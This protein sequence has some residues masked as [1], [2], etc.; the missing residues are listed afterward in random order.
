MDGMEILLSLVFVA[1]AVVWF[2]LYVRGKTEKQGVFSKH[3]LRESEEWPEPAVAAAEAVRPDASRYRVMVPLANPEHESSLITLAGSIAKQHENG[4]VVVVHIVEVPYQVPLEAGARRVDELD[5]ESTELLARARRDAETQGVDVET[6]TIMARD[7]FPAIF[8]AAQ[9]QK[10]DMVV[11]GWGPDAHGSPGRVQSFAGDLLGTLACDFVVF[12]DRG[13][14]PSRVLVP[15][16]GGPASEVSAQVARVLRDAFGAEITLYNVA[17]TEADRAAH[18][19]HLAR[20]A[21]VH[22][23]SDAAQVVDVADDIGAAIAA[24]AEAHSLLILG[25]TEEGLLTRLTGDIGALEVVEQ[26]DTSVILAEGA[27]ERSFLERLLGSRGEDF[28]LVNAME[29]VNGEGR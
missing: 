25:A 23:L 22:D 19:E 4:V 2:Y 15:T 5:A 20:W 29:R 17:P 24:Q 3:I 11:L 13:F 18:E 8:D 7:A 10:A 9:T 26:V 1:V 27:H 28:G 21:E 14:D 16:R 6:H 12:K